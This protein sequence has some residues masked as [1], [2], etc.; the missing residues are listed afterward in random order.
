ELVSEL[1]EGLEDA[2][3]GETEAKGEVEFLRGE[4]ERTKLELKQEKERSATALRN[5]EERANSLAALTSSEADRTALD[6]KDERIRSLEA[7][8]DSLQTSDSSSDTK[9]NMS[10]EDKAAYEKRIQELEQ[11][12]ADQARR[13]ADLE[14][15]L[16]A[17]HN[18]PTQPLPLR[19]K[20]SMASSLG[21]TSSRDQRRKGSHNHTLSDRTVVPNEHE[22][23]QAHANGS[24]LAPRTPNHYAPRAHSRIDSEIEYGSSPN[25]EE[26]LWCEICETSGH[27]ILTC[28]NMFGS[29]GGQP[30]S[31]NNNGVNHN[32][33]NF[34]HD[35]SSRRPSAGAFSNGSRRPSLHP[36]P[37]QGL[38]ETPRMEH[39][40]M[41]APSFDSQDD[42]RS[43]LSASTDQ[44][45]QLPNPQQQYQAY[46]G[47]SSGTKPAASPGAT[48]QRSARD[49][50]LERMRSN[51]SM[52]PL[53]GKESG[54]VDESKWCALC[55]RDGHE[56]IDC[57]FD[58]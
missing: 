5:A 41:Y 58:E 26:T 44:H 16:Q 46:G 21:S 53:A 20:P 43:Y 47:G 28:T 25:S 19:P 8:I 42:A 45:E 17:S 37:S 38:P 14:R 12:L 4:V 24:H 50:V 30:T 18:P 27:E 52:G 32:A 1:E 7:I 40:Q 29:N 10:A 2:R 48:S 34:E 51:G 33:F 6:Q 22:V 55:E 3:R 31:N 9:G 57:P 36:P 49:V 23:Q 11:H 54:V 39:A 35:D 56:S 15:E 13:M